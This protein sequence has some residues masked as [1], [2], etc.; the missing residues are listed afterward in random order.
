MALEGVPEH[1][2]KDPL[3]VAGQQHPGS[4]GLQG[5]Q[6][7]REENGDAQDPRGHGAKDGLPH[8]GRTPTGLLFRFTPNVF[9]RIL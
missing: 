5:K 7:G 4:P 8:C 9:G 1:L 6:D 2:L 3:V